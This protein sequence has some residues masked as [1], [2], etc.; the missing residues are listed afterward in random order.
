MDT[1]THRAAAALLT[2]RRIGLLFSTT[3]GTAFL[4]FLTNLVLSRG[5]SMEG[6]G[7][8]SA[9]LAAINIATPIAS[10][11]LGWVWLEL[12]GREGR[13]AVRWI[14]PALRLAAV[15][16]LLS[17]AFLVLYVVTT[18]SHREVGL[19]TGLLAIPIL[20]GQTLVDSTA[21]RF[22]LEERYTA[23]ALWQL[24]TQAGRSLVAFALVAMGAAGTVALLTGYAIVGIVVCAVSWHSV[25]RVARGDIHFAG[26]PRAQAPSGATAPRLKEVLVHVAPYSLV[27]LLYL[28]GSQAIVAVVDYRIGSASAA[29]YNVA[30]LVTS[31]IYLFPSVVYGKYLASK[32]LRWWNH[33]RPMFIAVFHVALAGH[34]IVGVVCAVLVAVLAPLVIPFVFGARYRESVDVL[35]ILAFCIPFRF[36]QHAYGSLMLSKEHIRRKIAYMACASVT[37]VGLAYMLTPAQGLKGAAAAALV[38]ELII[39]VL[40]V[41]GASRYIEGINVLDSLRLSSL[42]RSFMHVYRGGSPAGPIG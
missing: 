12:F 16:T 15:A 40:Y 10:V 38:A 5:M 4:A 39:F 20:L 8:L 42:R 9:L 36:A 25:R 35:A 19:R 29:V 1:N 6:Y 18:E 22:Q 21:A 27:T 34:V 37:S 7:R 17:S 32:L 41:H 11:G 2:A 24:V 3:I 23:L 13:A 28:V 26:H 33:D 14:A 30:F 31:L